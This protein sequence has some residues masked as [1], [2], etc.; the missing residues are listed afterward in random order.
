[1]EIVALRRAFSWPGY[2]S[3]AHAGLEGEWVTPYHVTCSN[4][5]GPV[6]LTYNFLDAPTAREHREA[7]SATGYL[8]AMRFNRVLDLAL[9]LAG[10]SRSDIYVTHAFHLL[11]NTRIRTSILS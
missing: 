6:L 5:T 9:E 2:E 3:Y 11:A 7:L 4:P 1:M 8:P 10:L